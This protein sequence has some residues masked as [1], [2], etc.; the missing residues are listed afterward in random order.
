[1][2]EY[3][4]FEYGDMRFPSGEKY[5]VFF[6]KETSKL[7]V[8]IGDEFLPLR[9]FKPDAYDLWEIIHKK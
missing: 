3:H 8:K 4:L 2:N 9:Y 6:E 5:K 1:M 7:I